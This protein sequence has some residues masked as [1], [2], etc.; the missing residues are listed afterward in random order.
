MVQLSATRCGC[1]ATLWV[2][3]ASF[4]AI[5]LCVA[6][7]RVFCC[8]CCFCFCLFRYGLSPETC[9]YAPYSPSVSGHEN[10]AP[11]VCFVIIVITISR[12]KFPFLLQYIKCSHSSID[13]PLNSTEVTNF[14]NFKA[15]FVSTGKE[16]LESIEIRVQLRVAQSIACSVSHLGGS[17]FESRPWHWISWLKFVRYFSALTTNNWS[18][19]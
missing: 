16:A 2:S 18:V 14:R 8:C 4:A 19:Y 7:Q 10:T 9:G 15:H 12:R 5:T 3:L 1:I 17:R 6:S 11:R 13:T